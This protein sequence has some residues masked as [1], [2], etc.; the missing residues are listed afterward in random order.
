LAG[1]LNE[2]VEYAGK[3][4]AAV[5]G[6]PVSPAAGRLTRLSKRNRLDVCSRCT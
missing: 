3:P 5:D 4:D 2:G 6:G 1:C